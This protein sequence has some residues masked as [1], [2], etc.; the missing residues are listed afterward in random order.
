MTD[1]ARVHACDAMM[2]PDEDSSAYLLACARID[3]LEREL[4]DA[5]QTIAELRQLIEDVVCN[6]K[7]NEDL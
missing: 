3:R 2:D 7:Y 5:R 4:I 1:F 6:N